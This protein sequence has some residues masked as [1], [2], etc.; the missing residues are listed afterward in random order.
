MDIDGSSATPGEKQDADQAIQDHENTKM[1]IYD[2]ATQT[3]EAK[4]QKR[5]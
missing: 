4:N 5:Q 3:K 1:G 2:A